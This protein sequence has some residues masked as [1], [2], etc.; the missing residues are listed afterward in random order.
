[1]LLSEMNWMDVEEYLK[2]DKRIVLVTGAVEQHGYISLSTDTLISYEIALKAAEAE[3][4]VVAPPLHYGISTVFADYPG[5]ISLSAQTY[6]SVIGDIVTSVY[7][8]GFR[9]VLILNGHGG[10]TPMRAALC[11]L[12]DRLDGLVVRAIEW[13]KQPE[14]VKL[15]ESIAPNP[16]HAN[17]VENFSFCRTG[18]VP[19]TEKEMVDL[20]YAP[21]PRQTKELLGDGVFGGPYRAPDEKMQ[22]LF[23][24]VVEVA[25]KAISEL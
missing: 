11:E 23:D 17:W 8:S 1:M 7:R 4:V 3:G 5:T 9:K 19:D 21:S 24:K 12:A 16:T 10:N 15:A 2:R 6:L 22:I 25:R 18:E 14:I 20:P 13:W